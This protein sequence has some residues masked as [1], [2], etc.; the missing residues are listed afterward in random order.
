MLLEA[1]ALLNKLHV[2]ET[3]WAYLD[4]K[5]KKYVFVIHGLTLHD[6]VT[7]IAFMCPIY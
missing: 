4:A 5:E 7:H 2:S 1:L 6:N 3:L